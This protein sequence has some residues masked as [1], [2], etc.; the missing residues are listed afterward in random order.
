MAEAQAETGRLAYARNLCKIRGRYTTTTTT[1]IGRKRCLTPR[2]ARGGRAR[3]RALV[4]K[5]NVTGIVVGG[6]N[7]GLLRRV[8]DTRSAYESRVN[9]GGFCACECGIPADEE[10][11]VIRSVSRRVVA[12]CV[13]PAGKYFPHF[14]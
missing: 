10:Q 6:D 14:P 9:Y 7:E 3:A 13:P 8:D 11:S 5:V 2:R 1:R 4:T 12:R